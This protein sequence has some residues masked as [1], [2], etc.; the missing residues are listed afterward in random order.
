MTAPRLKLA[1][2]PG[3]PRYLT[4]A[5]AAAYVG[6]SV[7]T[8]ETEVTAGL[9]PLPRKR[10]ARGGKPTWDRHLLDQFADAAAELPPRHNREAP[11]QSVGDV[12]WDR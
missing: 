7:G 1:D 11:T 2:L 3:W 10:G 8:F 4:L 6:V 9:W 5:E 12:A